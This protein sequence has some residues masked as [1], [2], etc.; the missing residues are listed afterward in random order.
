MSRTEPA[1][2]NAQ[3]V[4]T[5]KAGDGTPDWLRLDSEQDQMAF[6]RWFSFLAEVQYFNAPQNRPAEIV[7]CSA[8]VRYCYREALRFHDSRWAAESNLPLIPALASVRKYNY[9]VV[10]FSSGL[11]RI[12]PGPFHQG[13]QVN[14]V[15]AQ[16]ANAKTLQLFNTYRITRDVGRAQSGDLLFF[17]RTVGDNP[18][19]YHSM[20]FIGRSQVEPT[21]ASYVVYDTGPEGGNTGEIRRLSLSDLIHFPDPQW[22]PYPAN[23]QFL[24]IFRWNILRDL[25]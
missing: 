12:G 24:G 6:R 18:D 8:L 7:D 13:D 9:P 16:F 20:I 19:S 15:F 23:H 2:Q 3:P 4:W 25:S 14:G 11:F 22:R 5:D 21:P 17:R 10:G 1:S